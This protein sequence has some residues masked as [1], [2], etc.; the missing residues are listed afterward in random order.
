MAKK[1]LI[2]FISSTKKESEKLEDFK[3]LKIEKTKL[4]DIYFPNVMPNMTFAQ[5]EAITLA[6]KYGYYDFPR[7][8]EL[9]ELS[10]ISKKSLSTF[11]EHLRKAEKN[12][13]PELTKNLD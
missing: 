13:M 12:I 2:E 11:R 8:I 5:K 7:R 9:K 6:Q 10:K 1:N 4:T 3:I